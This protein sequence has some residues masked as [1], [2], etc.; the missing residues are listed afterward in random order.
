MVKYEIRKATI[1]DLDAIFSIIQKVGT[2]Y[3]STSKFVCSKNNKVYEN[4]ILSSPAYVAVSE[5]GEI[6]GSLLLHHDT[7]DGE[8]V[9]KA[10]GLNSKEIS[11]TIIFETCE[12]LPEHRGNSLQYLLCKQ[13]LKE[14]KAQK[15][16]KKA[17]CTVHPD[18]K[19]SLRNMEKIGFK[20]AQLT[21]LYLGYD[22]F[23]LIKKI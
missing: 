21:K 22:R 18:N 7:K 5:N 19:Y 12:V 20:V 2:E 9:Y 15:Y 16:Y 13:A 17:V 11:T 3:G 10:A 14:L 1:D 23:V 4:M 6:V 8:G